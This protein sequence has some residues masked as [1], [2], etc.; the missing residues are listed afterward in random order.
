M[1][2]F[3]INLFFNIKDFVTENFVS[4][5]VCVFIARSAREMGYSA[6][7]WF[8]TSLLYAPLASLYL[9]TALPNRNI[10]KKRKKEM[11]LL[12]EQLSKNAFARRGGSSPISDHTISDDKTMR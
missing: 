1:E 4:I 9:L 5:I 7:L 2:Y 12:K 11:I 8:F 6:W 3:V 10:E